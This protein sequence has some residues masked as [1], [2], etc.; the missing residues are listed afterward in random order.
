VTT[1]PEHRPISISSATPAT[2]GKSLASP[3]WAARPRSVPPRPRSARC[4][5][6]RSPTWA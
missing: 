2:S 4:R 1:P 5:L 3:G 6:A